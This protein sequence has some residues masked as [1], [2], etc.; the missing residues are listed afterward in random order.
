M[1]ACAGGGSS[2]DAFMTDFKNAGLTQARHWSVDVCVGEGGGGGGRKRGSRT[3]RLDKQVRLRL[4]GEDNCG[5]LS[6]WCMEADG[7][8][9]SC[10]LSVWDLSGHTSL[11]YCSGGSGWSWKQDGT[12]G[13]LATKTTHCHPCSNKK[14]HVGLHGWWRVVL[15]PGSTASGMHRD[16]GR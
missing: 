11:W 8:K 6:S 9:N 1:W 14:L 7:P 10:R 16:P 15:D 12:H 3:Q 4:M 13:L 5:S 2:L